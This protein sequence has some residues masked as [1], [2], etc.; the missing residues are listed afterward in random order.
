MDFTWK[1]LVGICLF[2]VIII[3]LPIFLCSNTMMT[4]YQK[5]IDAEPN[6]DNHKWLQL[7]MGDI[8]FKTMRPEMSAEYYRKFRD[9][10]KEDERRPYAYFRYAR[11][12]E[13]SDR[14]ADAIAEFQRFIEEYPD[15]PEA[16][17]AA[18]GID[19]I[20]YTKPIK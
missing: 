13:D 2:F 9:N 19:R 5:K 15:R 14:N 17:D 20:K 1:K 16:K 11:S 6:T 18:I 7:K 12:L 8:C 3:L 4:Y 10:Y